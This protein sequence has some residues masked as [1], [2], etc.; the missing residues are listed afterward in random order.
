VAELR[1][2]I[3]EAA[4]EKTVG[5]GRTIRLLNPRAA[6]EQ[7]V[8]RQDVE[9]RRRSSSREAQHVVSQMR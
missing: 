3:L 1:G 8:E 2:A 7:V 6:V 5:E 9:G 4:D